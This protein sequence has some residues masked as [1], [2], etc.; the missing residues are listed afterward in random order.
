[1]TNSTMARFVCLLAVVATACSSVAQEVYDYSW[2]IEHEEACADK[3]LGRHADSV[4][5]PLSTTLVVT[6]RTLSDDF[7]ERQVTL[8]EKGSDS[9]E[10]RFSQI[11]GLSIE[12]QLYELHE[13]EPEASADELCSKIKVATDEVPKE[14]A[15]ELQQLVS[16][17]GEHQFALTPG[18]FFT[19]HG[20]RYKVWISSGQWEAHFDFVDSSDGSRQTAIARWVERLFALFGQ[21]NDPTAPDVDPTPK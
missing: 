7:A 1:M 9:V 15:G 18:S 19:I 16:E 3:L 4:G 10:A 20:V 5:E 17:L 11:V 21:D 8:I 14:K 12:E 2:A 13:A 6:A